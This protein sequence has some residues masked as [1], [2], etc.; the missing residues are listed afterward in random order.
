MLFAGT[1]LAKRIEG[2]DCRLLSG[3]TAVLGNKRPDGGTFVRPIA[4]GVAVFAG[5]GSPLNKIAGVG[6][7]GPVD[8]D[9]L[10]E[11]ERAFDARG[12]A[13][14]AEVSS[15]ADPE[16]CRVFSRRGYQLVG[17]ENV[18][19]R[20]LPASELA[21]VPDVHV[22]A[23]KD[24]SGWVHV[25]VTGFLTPDGQGVATHE[26]FDRTV[27]E[28]DITDTSGAAGVCT[29]LASRDGADAGGARMRIDEAGVAQLCGASTL[30]EH[31]RRGVQTALLHTRLAAASAA[32]W[33]VAAMT[34]QPGSKS[35]ENAQRRGFELLYTRAI[36]VRELR[37]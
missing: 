5:E 16:A 15:L 33:E 18:L 14:Q 25:L 6:F 10:S 13:V 35:H 19:G 2:A 7:G 12:T 34:T 29:Y 4:G 21:A 24:S 27:L 30:P 8:I 26:A 37:P 23:A 31:R 3:S 17:M 11:I 1:T 32:G 36:L 20:P 28:R 9:I 22:A